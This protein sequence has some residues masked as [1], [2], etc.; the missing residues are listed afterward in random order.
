MIKKI[1]T[2]LVLLMLLLAVVPTPH[3]QAEKTAAELQEERKQLQ[4]RL[5]ELNRMLNGIRDDVE[6]ARQKAATYKER[7][8]IIERQIN[9]QKEII[10]LKNEE[11]STLQAALDAKQRERDATYE[12][13]KLRVRAMYMNNNS[14]MLEALLGAESFSD[15]LTDAEMLSRISKHDVQLIEKLTQE[16]QA[17][18]DGKVVVEQELV[19]LEDEKA[20]LDAKYN[21]LALL[22]REAN[23]ELDD[24]EA[25]QKATEEERLAAIEEIERNQKEWND[26]MG[27]GEAG[28][29]GTG[30]YR[31]PL[32]GYS[33]I[34]S[35]FGMRYIFGA[36][37]MH[38]GIDIS[39]GNVYGKPIVAADAGRVASAVYG[40]GGY[41]YY[42]ILDHGNNNWT[43]YAHMSAIAVKQGDY[44]MQGTTLG[45]VGSTGQSTGPHLHF[46]IRIKGTPVDPLTLVAY[47]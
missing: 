9:I 17:L 14:T 47:T 16:E 4:Q 43:V 34:T 28:S 2:G 18:A 19:T 20:A 37:S 26:L 45:Y 10:A 30:S 31:W 7:Q 33:N 35:K 24:A 38:N 21:E 36:W 1:F 44:V 25:R 6:R 42:V 12:L 27:T 39:G 5:D 3:A 46:E 40:T 22:Y 15:F 11:L 32:P 8:E 29:I 23:A 41:G 13:F